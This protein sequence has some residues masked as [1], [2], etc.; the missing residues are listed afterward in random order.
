MILTIIRGNI[1]PVTTLVYEPRYFEFNRAD[2]TIEECSE[3]LTVVDFDDS[4][5]NLSLYPGDEVWLTGK[6]GKT[7]NRWKI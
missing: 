6:N 2:S 1:S 5:V 4:A 3:T 7:A